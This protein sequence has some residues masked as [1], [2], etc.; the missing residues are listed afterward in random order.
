M[1]G[2]TAPLS[3]LNG[4]TALMS[5]L[6]EDMPARP[7]LLPPLPLVLSLLAKA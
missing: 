7:L 6:D 4:E 2:F 5:I 3:T 1:L